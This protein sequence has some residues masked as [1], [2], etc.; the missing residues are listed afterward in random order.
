MTLYDLSVP[1]ADGAQRSL[2][3]YRGK[4]LLVANTASTCGFTPQYRELEELYQRY[5]SQGLEILAFPCNQFLG[6]EKGSNDEIQTFCRLHYGVTFPVFGKIDVK[7]EDAHP[8][9]RYLTEH[10]SGWFGTGIKWNFTKF[11]VDAQG[12]VRFRYAPTTRPGKI[13]PDLKLLLREE[14]EK[15]LAWHH[16]AMHEFP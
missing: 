8:L 11:L 14:Q 2:A 4:V 12:K 1:M 3:A 13:V 6:Q 5:A 10:A 15:T 16:A 7:G 9:F